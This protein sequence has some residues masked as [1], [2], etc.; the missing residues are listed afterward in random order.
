MC[1][2]LPHALHQNNLITMSSTAHVIHCQNLY[3]VFDTILD[4]ARNLKDLKSEDDTG[5]DYFRER[6]IAGVAACQWL[7]VNLSDMLKTELDW[8]GVKESCDPYFNRLCAGCKWRQA[9]S[10]LTREFKYLVEMVDG[11]LTSSRE[12][13]ETEAEEGSAGSIRMKAIEFSLRSLLAFC[14]KMRDHCP[15]SFPIEKKLAKVRA[16]MD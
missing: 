16:I 11:C 12:R 4:A 2:T 7:I 1:F 6:S 10:E 15:K 13:K 8:C 5:S 3:K 9:L 14:E